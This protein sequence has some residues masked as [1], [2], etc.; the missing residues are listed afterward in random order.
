MNRNCRPLPDLRKLRSGCARPYLDDFIEALTS[1]GY[2]RRTIREHLGGTVHLGRWAD[3]AGVELAELDE[4]VIA[5]YVEHV[6]V[7]RCNKHKRRRFARA[8]KSARVFLDHLRRLGVARPGTTPVGQDMPPLLVSYLTWMK[9]H[10]G[11]TEAT[12]DLYERKIRVF[13]A[14]AGEDPSAYE[15]RQ[16]RSFIMNRISGLGCSDAKLLVTAVRSF[17]RFLGLEGLCAVGL[18]QAI[19]TVPQ[20]RLSSLPRYLE[21]EVVD[22]V[23][24]ACDLARVSGR[25]DRAVLLMLVRLGLR[26]GDVVGMRLG[27]IDWGKGT[28]LV[29]GKGRRDSLLPLPQDV[30]EALLSYLEHGRPRTTLD[31][32]FLRLRAPHQA[33]RFSSSISSLVCSALKRAGVDHAP[34]RGAHLMRH[35][36][37][38]A[39]L[40]AGCTLDAI[41]TVLRHQSL[42][43]TAHYAKVDLAALQ[44]IVQPWPE[45][46][47]C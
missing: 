17:L 47:P 1:A 10:R 41:A 43:T 32:V 45:G 24:A 12:L 7:C 33:L 4:G 40:R 13:L 27:D 23:L 21:S 37:A 20:W 3:H 2:T 18:D 22:R 16:I 35:S 15:A 14:G 11:V 30:G 26:A 28:L 39:M 5:R 46:A 34:W 25:R 19:P 31:H 36:A 42:E 8:E 9:Q 29:R 44:T 38:T 6:R